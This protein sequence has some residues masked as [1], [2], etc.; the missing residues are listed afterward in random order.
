LLERFNQTLLK[1]EIIMRE[2]FDREYATVETHTDAFKAYQVLRAGFF[3]LP[4][5]AGLDKFFHFLVNWDVY[6]APQVANMLPSSGLPLSA[7]NFM[8][9][10][11]VIEIIAGL[12]V[13]IAPRFGGWLVAVWLWGIIANLI[14][15]GAYYDI[16]LRDF[17]LSLGAVAL[18]LLSPERR[19]YYR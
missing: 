7:H 19:T 5:I 4:V 18:S 1:E 12:V 3:L 16:A 17:G 8:Q 13:A 2:R 15:G 10:A 11:G 14:L 6:L 9:I